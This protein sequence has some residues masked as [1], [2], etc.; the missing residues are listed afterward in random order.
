MKRIGLIGEDPYDKTAIK[1]LLVRKFDMVHFQPLLRGIRGKGLD[2]PKTARALVQEL[3]GADYN[4]LI[5][6]RD[7]DGLPSQV[8]I[9]KGLNKWFEA[10][11]HKKTDMLLMNIWELETLIF[12]DIDV[13]NKKYG[14]DVKCKGDPMMISNPKEKLISATYKTKS[15]FHES[16]CPDLFSLLDIDKVSAKCKYFA[17]FLSVLQGRLTA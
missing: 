7:L 17:E 8:D 5:F 15:Q 9:Q 14:A 12:G 1:N 2:S 10:L 16:D 4:F 6:I 13:F 3:K 11:K